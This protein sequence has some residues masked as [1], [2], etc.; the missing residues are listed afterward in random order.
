M[1]TKELHGLYGGNQLLIMRNHCIFYLILHSNSNS[2]VVD[3][4]V[5]DSSVNFLHVDMTY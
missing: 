3:S 1:E 2:K 5:L 4:R